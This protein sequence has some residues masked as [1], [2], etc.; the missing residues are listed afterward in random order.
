MT[1]LLERAGGRMA[2][3]WAQRTAGSR[4]AVYRAGDH[5]EGTRLYEQSLA[6]AGAGDDQATASSL[7]RLSFMRRSALDCAMTRS[8]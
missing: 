8:W 6:L 1:T 2:L 7:P 3:S 4:S 5:D